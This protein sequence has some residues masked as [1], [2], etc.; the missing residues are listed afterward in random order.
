MTLQTGLGIGKI[1]TDTFGNLWGARQQTRAADRAAEIS[2]RTALDIANME[3]EGLDKQ[4]EYLRE[5]DARDYN[6]WLAREARDRTDWENSERRRAPFRALAD[7]AVRTLADYIRVPGMRPAQDVPVQQWT[8]QPAPVTTGQAPVNTTMP[9][10][11]PR[12]AGGFVGPQPPAR[13]TLAD[14]ARG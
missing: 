3:R 11:D 13:R 5:V 10:R 14:F 1:L 12:M 4:L 6:D 8:H 7:S 2:S 9:V